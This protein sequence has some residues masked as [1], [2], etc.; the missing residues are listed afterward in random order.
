LLTLG[1]FRSSL[2]GILSNLPF[3][4]IVYFDFIVLGHIH[5]DDWIDH[6]AESHRLD[7][8]YPFISLY[9]LFSFVLSMSTGY[10]GLA[11][12]LATSVFRLG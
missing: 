8:C 9:F 10:F 2:H 5:S 11:Y 1:S 3:Y 6:R 7:S 4:S 12:R